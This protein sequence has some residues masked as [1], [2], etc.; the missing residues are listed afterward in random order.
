MEKQKLKS[1]KA[2]FILQSTALLQQDIETKFF[3]DVYD[4]SRWNIYLRIRKSTA[5]PFLDIPE[6]QY[7]IVFSG[8]RYIQEH[9]IDSFEEVQAI[10]KQEYTNF[11]DANKTFFIGAER[12]DL[13]GTVLTYA[14]SKVLGLSVWKAHLS[15][16]E[17]KLRSQ[18]PTISGNSFTD[19]LER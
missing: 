7:E 3:T 10:D 16:E 5:E 6:D 1:K 9:L 15:D 8:Y 17:I 18:N 2:K 13:T 11:K 12:Q 19:M 14:D 4:N